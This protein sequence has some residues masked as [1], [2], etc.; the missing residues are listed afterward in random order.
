MNRLIYK[1]NYIFPDIKIENNQLIIYQANMQNVGIIVDLNTFTFKLI[2]MM[3]NG[4]CFDIKLYA[5]FTGYIYLDKAIIF[6]FEYQGNKNDDMINNKTNLMSSL[7]PIFDKLN[8]NGISVN[9]TFKEDKKKIYYLYNNNIFWSP[10]RK[11]TFSCNQSP[12]K[13]YR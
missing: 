4:F 10:Y 2:R 3:N 6:E 5:L 9:L 1:L 11:R 8:Y 12:R 7:R 13:E